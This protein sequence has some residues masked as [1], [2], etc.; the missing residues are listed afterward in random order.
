M[1]RA[2][3]L[4]VFFCIIAISGCHRE[5][6]GPGSPTS[7]EFGYVANGITPGR[8][9]EFAIN[10]ETGAWAQIPG[11]PFVEGA[12]EPHS[13]AAAPSSKFLYVVNRGDSDISVLSIDSATGSLAA[14]GAPTRAPIN[15]LNLATHPAGNFLYVTNVLQP[16]TV[17]AFSIDRTNGTLSPVP[18]SPFDAGAGI[19]DSLAIT[20]SGKFLYVTNSPPSIISAYAIDSGTGALTPITGS[21]FAAGMGAKAIAVSPGGKF[22][23]VSD[24][25]GG[26]IL[27][28][29][30]SEA[31]GALATVAGSPFP[32]G[33][34]PSAL[35]IDPRANFLYAI[36]EATLGTISAFRIDQNS[37]ALAGVAGSPFSTGPAAS[38]ITIDPS[39]RF[40][41]ATLQLED[42]GKLAS[43]RIDPASGALKAIDGSPFDAGPDPTAVIIVQ[44]K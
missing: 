12:S 33:S 17:S 11:S 25:Y 41:S 20:P 10:P 35:A 26:T 23:Y 36:N 6:G 38:A 24:S 18:R 27:A 3:S 14:V 32:A 2:R 15:A 42:N 21:P 8:V 30:I 34:H 5:S 9:S 31:S 16:G 40:L 43:F 7:R 28:Y 37:G 22:L 1:K 4:C 44:S 39:G 13:I 29:A 19:S